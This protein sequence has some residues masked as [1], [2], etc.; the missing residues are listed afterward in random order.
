MKLKL[1]NNSTGWKYD[2][3]VINTTKLP[4]IEKE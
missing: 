4:N 2:S 1:K 3:V